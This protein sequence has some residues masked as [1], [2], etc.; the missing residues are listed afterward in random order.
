MV[1]I[2][3][4]YQRHRNLSCVTF[5]GRITGEF[6]PCADDFPDITGFAVAEAYARPAAG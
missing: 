2:I 5:P 3:E 1:E 4:S 6:A